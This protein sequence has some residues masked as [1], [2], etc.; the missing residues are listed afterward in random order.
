[1]PPDHSRTANH[2]TLRLRRRRLG[3]YLDV[4]GFTTSHMVDT[5]FSRLITA[6]WSLYQ[7]KKRLGDV[8]PRLQRFFLRLMRYDFT[9]QFLPGRKLVLA[10]ALSRAG[11]HSPHHKQGL[12]DVEV[13]AVGMLAALVSETTQDRLRTETQRDPEL[14]HVLH[15][16]E[17]GYPLQGNF[18]SLDPELS[19]VNGIILK[20][21]RVVI[22]SSLRRVMLAR[23]HQGHL[24]VNKCKERGRQLMF[25]PKMAQDIHTFVAECATCKKFAYQQ[26][27]EPLMM[28]E[29]PPYAWY[30][31]GIDLFAYG[32]YSYLV[33]FDA[34]SNYPEVERLQDTCSQTII[35]T[36]S[37]WFARHGIPIEVC[38]DNGPQFSSSEFKR[39]S[40][41][42]DFHHVTSSPHFPQSNGLAEK[43][44][45]IAKRI[46]KK[47]DDAGEDF[48]LGLLN[49]RCSPL[50]GG[51]SPGELLYGRKLRAQ[52]PDFSS[53]PRKPVCK[54]QQNKPGT[55]LKD[56]KSG[57]VV[58][59][60]GKGG[61]FEKARV[62]NCAGPRS[63]TVQTERNRIYR[64]NRR[65]LLK[66]SEA[67][68]D[69]LDEDAAS[70]QQHSDA[71]DNPQPSQTSQS[72]QLPQPHCNPDT[73]HRS[74]HPSPASG[75]T[76]TDEAPALRRS[77]R[78]RHA[79]RRLTYDKTF[80]QFP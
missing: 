73:D 18:S 24:G 36:L 3:W 75:E 66:T 34:Y 14:Q 53:H 21:T 39:F 12:E 33:A 11:Q 68:N 44:V 46:L 41:V 1:M 30:R 52:L 63:Y 78:S 45:Q 19:V 32:G 72:P 76:L 48:F 31:V 20:G 38:S 67:F 8:P 61:W 51:Q 64:R 49:Y 26:P 7:K 71:H 2:D 80:E 27:R 15:C 59:M 70:P 79:P 6:R 50:I 56:L 37:G 60:R 69:C 57:D 42:Y 17:N 28:R 9:L 77:S 62:T 22:S 47:C 54:R 25:W 29:P 16:L 74:T 58:R 55:S 65:H 23:V 5:S 10:D 4:R 40:R 35:H 43:G 13:H